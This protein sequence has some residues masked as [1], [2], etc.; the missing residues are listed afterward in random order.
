MTPPLTTTTSYWCRVSNAAGSADSAAA[1]ITVP[2][3]CN[4]VPVHIELEPNDSS[5]APRTQTIEL[6]RSSGTFSFKYHTGLVADRLRVVYQGV[7]LFDT[8]CVATGTNVYVTQSIFYSGTSTSVVVEVTPN[9]A[10]GTGSG[11]DYEWTCPTAPPP[12]QAA[13]RTA[14]ASPF[15]VTDTETWRHR[16]LHPVRRRAA[17]VHMFTFDKD[18]KIYFTQ[19]VFGG[20]VG[21]DTPIWPDDT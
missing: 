11:W 20:R 13:G 3:L 14:Y 6:G 19:A 4:P 15:P 2:A 8:G 9:C 16:Q 5:Q 12:A 1:T 7:T 18:G 10:G 17:D 21:P